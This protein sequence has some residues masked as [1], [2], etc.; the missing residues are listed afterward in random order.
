MARANVPVFIARLENDS[1]KES[2]FLTTGIKQ[3]WIEIVPDEGFLITE[4]G[5]D[6][7]RNYGLDTSPGKTKT[8]GDWL[9]ESKRLDSIKFA[10]D[11][12][13]AVANTL[14]TLGVSYQLRTIKK[15]SIQLKIDVSE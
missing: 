11:G 8:L 13:R 10:S 12:N 9:E 5:K 3:E 1:W 2:E 6:V 15:I 7:L 14:G 4:K